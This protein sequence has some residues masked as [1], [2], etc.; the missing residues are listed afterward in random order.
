[1]GPLRLRTVFDTV[2]RSISKFDIPILRT[3]WELLW[4][5]GH[6][7][8]AW[9]DGKRR[10]YSNPV[11]FAV[12]AGII[13]A[14]V[15]RLFLD[16][17]TVDSQEVSTTMKLTTEYLAF[18]LFLL[19]VP[20]GIVLGVTGRIFRVSRSWLDWFV[21]G[22]FTFGIAAIVQVAVSLID[23]AMGTASLG[24]A[25]FAGLLPVVWMIWGGWG[26][27]PAGQR[28]RSLSTVLIGGTL[29]IVGLG[30]VQAVVVALLG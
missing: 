2:L 14:V 24:L 27:A 8:A 21:L 9:V 29:A 30:V 26:F 7:A 6:V 11:K 5:P 4:R 25:R 12:I 10:T 28:G 23:S 18:V 1:M 16:H 15:Y 22:L 19:A 3:G 20:L 17:L 13:V